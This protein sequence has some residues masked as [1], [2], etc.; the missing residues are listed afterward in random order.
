MATPATN[1]FRCALA[2][3][4][5]TLSALASPASAEIEMIAAP[6]DRG[7]SFHWW[8]KLT[9]PEG[10]HHDR[11]FSFHYSVNAIAPDGLYFDDA[12]TVMYAKAAYKPREP[13]V[14]SLEMFIERDHKSFKA[15]ARG[16]EIKE[17]AALT[18]ADGKRLRSFT[19]FP[20]QAGNWERVA[21]GEEGDYY[22]IFTISSRSKSGYEAASAAYE[23]LVRGYRERAPAA[24]SG[25]DVTR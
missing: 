22:L 15:D 5:L 7:L 20:T 13:D 4:G 18:T 12:E 16:L 17:T 10:W 8:P 21:Y 11:N 9:P 3:L 2:A 23:S 1:L 6:T 14:K 25:A 24:P 19:F